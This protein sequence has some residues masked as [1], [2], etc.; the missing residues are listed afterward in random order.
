MDDQLWHQAMVV[1]RHQEE[2]RRGILN[3]L[4]AP[5]IQGTDDDTILF[6]L[7]QKGIIDHSD[8]DKRWDGTTRSMRY[9]AALGDRL[10]S[11]LESEHA[12]VR[13]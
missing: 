10:W 12:R 3:S 6:Y 2:V 1:H 4:N 8:F 9:T 5:G 7:I 13:Q 11:L